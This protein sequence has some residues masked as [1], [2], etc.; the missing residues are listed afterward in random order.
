MGTIS[1]AG[2]EVQIL[3]F[4]GDKFDK[5]NLH[6]RGWN[7]GQLLNLVQAYL[8]RCQKKY[9]CFLGGLL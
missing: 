9:I 3:G 4:F 7:F 1:K 5:E 8:L 2:N 6:F